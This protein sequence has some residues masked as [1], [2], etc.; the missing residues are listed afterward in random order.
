MRFLGPGF[1]PHLPGFR[2]QFLAKALGATMWFFIFYR[3][4]CVTTRCTLI[5]SENP[6][7]V[8][9]QD[10]AKLLVWLLP[11]CTLRLAHLCSAGTKSPMGGPWTRAPRRA[12]SYTPIDPFLSHLCT[13]LY[14]AIPNKAP[15]SLH[16]ERPSF[17][18][19]PHWKK[20]DPSSN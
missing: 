17:L 20:L 5:A 1:H 6:L 13:I 14:V 19:N 15:Y 16:R 10:G 12:R 3:A 2:H 11:F 8:C 9:R 7:V 4:R 18:V